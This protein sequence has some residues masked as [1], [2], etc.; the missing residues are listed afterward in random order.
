MAWRVI[1]LSVLTLV[2][3]PLAQPA[4]AQ[5]GGQGSGGAG[6]G[7]DQASCGLQPTAPPQGLTGNWGGFRER[8]ADDG[9]GIDIRY[10]AQVGA[11]ISGGTSKDLTIPGELPIGATVDTAKLFG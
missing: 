5:Q 7:G 11:N 8:L 4:A 3:A 10:K 6:E 2:A 9:V 1:A